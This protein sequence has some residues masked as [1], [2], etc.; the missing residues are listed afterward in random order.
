MTEMSMNRVLRLVDGHSHDGSEP[1][2]SSSSGGCV[3]VVIGFK[4]RA[5]LLEPAEI[6]LTHERDLAETFFQDD[7]GEVNVVALFCAKSAET[8]D[9]LFLLKSSGPLPHAWLDMTMGEF[10][11]LHVG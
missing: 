5:E 6:T 1:C 9:H 10:E 2:C 4:R 11:G 3:Y 7:I 8:S